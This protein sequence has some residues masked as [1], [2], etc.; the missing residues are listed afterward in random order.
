MK[1]QAQIMRRFIAK[2]DPD[3]YSPERSL[4]RLN[5]LVEDILDV[6][7]IQTGRL[8]RWDKHR[9]DQV[10]TNLMTNAIRYASGKPLTAQVFRKESFAVF[11]LVDQGP[12][13]ALED[14][15]KIFQKFERL[16]TSNAI[17]GMGLGLFIVQ[18]IVHAHGGRIR[19]ESVRGLGSSFI[20]EL[21]LSG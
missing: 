21:P 6:S 17:S 11:A 18:E 12:G 8:G 10:V 13:I 20:V 5:R 19:V 2:G 16:V 3:A 4:D 1:L 15:S 7:R 9:L 14:Q